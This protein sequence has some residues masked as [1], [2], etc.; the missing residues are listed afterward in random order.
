MASWWRLFM[1]AVRCPASRTFCTAGMSRPIR[2]AMIAITTSSSISVKPVR[3]FR[4]R[5]IRTHL[6]FRMMPI[7]RTAA[8]LLLL[9]G[10]R[11]CFPVA[12]FQL[13]VEC[14]VPGSGEIAQRRRGEGAVPGVDVPEHLDHL[15]LELLH[16]RVWSDPR[17]V[18]A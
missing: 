16:A 13:Q 17:T 12:A 6:S 10:F 9:W 15:R 2:I 5:I 18:P 4:W 8:A 11:G 14:L 3:A 1:E 7:T